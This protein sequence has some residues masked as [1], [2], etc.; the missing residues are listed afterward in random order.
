MNPLVVMNKGQLLGQLTFFIGPVNF[1]YTVRRVRKCR[2][3]NTGESCLITPYVPHSF[4]S[5]DLSAPV[6]AIIAVTFSGHTR[7]ALSQLVH[8]N[9]NKV[10]QY[11]GDARNPVGVR[12]RL[13][14]RFAELRGFDNA[15]MT[16]SLAAKGVAT[17]AAEAMLH[18]EDGGAESTAILADLLNVHALELEAPLLSEDQEV[19]FAGEPLLGDAW[20]VRPGGKYGL[21]SAKHMSLC[22]GYDWV[23]E[24]SQ[25]EVPSQF[26]VFMFNY[27]DMPITI[28]WASEEDDVRVE[29]TRVL[30]PFASATFKPCIMTTV[31]VGEGEKGG[32]SVFKVPGCVNSGVMREISLFAQEGVKR[33]TTNHQAWF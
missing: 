11:A 21:A 14:E 22:G 4:T 17:E 1:Y 33:M 6:S 28:E 9:I 2:V 8:L 3:M 10:C 16:K 26:F 7:E 13:V 29:H 32:L 20:K 12:K 19:V 24:G 23:V 27:G 5:R 25:L 30:M 18:G 31:S 15:S